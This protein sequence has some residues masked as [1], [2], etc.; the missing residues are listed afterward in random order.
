VSCTLAEL[1][2]CHPR[3][4]VELVLAEEVQRGR[5]RVE[6]GDYL[7]VVEQFPPDVLAALARLAPP[8]LDGSGSARRVYVAARPGGELARAFS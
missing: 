7:L 5:V 4:V 8:E 1:A 3:A 6:D 2:V